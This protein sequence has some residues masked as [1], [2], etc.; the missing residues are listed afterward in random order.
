MRIAV[1]AIAKNEA[2]F[3]SRFLR[4]CAAADMVIVADTGST[5]GTPDLLRHGGAVVYSIAVTPWRFDRARDAALA[6]VPRDVDVCISLDVDEV[7]T[8]GWREEL[9][10]V[11]TPGTTRLRYQYEWGPGVV[12]G[13][14]KIH[15]RHGYHWHH[16]CHEYP[17]PDGRV[18]EVWAETD[19]LLVRHLPDATKSRGQYL[20]LLA[21]SVQEDPACPRN[22]FYY[23]RE[24]TFYGRHAD[25]VEA[26]RR[27]LALPAAT[28]A[29]ER[30]YAMRLLGTSYAA[31]GQDAEAVQWFR[32]AT[33]EAP[34]LRE[35][36]VDW[37]RFAYA[38]ADWL[39]CRYTAERAVAITVQ[40]PVYMTDPEAWGAL[41][42]DLAAIACYHLGAF[43][44]ATRHGARALA[45]APDDARLQSNLSFYRARGASPFREGVADVV[46][47]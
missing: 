3:V 42:H 22:A 4:S 25:A 36:W 15:A 16:P 26:L 32:R 6:L 30:A 12:F 34:D 45:Y 5:D 38:R 33:D 35:P 23:A 46:S 21:L 11:W 18:P 43:A 20:D 44:E 40:R 24:L 19:A 31:L 14:E 17:R 47:A 2:Q 13:Y 37:A 41:P 1:Y 27:Y 8:D 9:E 39:V 7:L 28:W 29:D 10:R